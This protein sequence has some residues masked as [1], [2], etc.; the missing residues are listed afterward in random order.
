M[1]VITGSAR[2]RK[3]ITLEGEEVIRPTADKVKEALFSIIQFE[4]EGASVLDLF[5]GSG[6]LGIEALSRGAKN[7]TFVDH[8][9][10][11]VEIIKQNL[12]NTNLFS[13]SVVLNSD[14]FAFLLNKK[15][16]YDIIFLDPPYKKQMVEKALPGACEVCRDSGIVICETDRDEEL[17]D[18]VG[19]FSKFKEYN[20]SKTKLTTYRKK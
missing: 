2:G 4:I 6:Q 11:A 12:K 1:R 8:S 5:A 13:Q 15:E 19:N 16:Q 17:P 18:E 7:A 20:H 14:S 10:D 3:L 9:R